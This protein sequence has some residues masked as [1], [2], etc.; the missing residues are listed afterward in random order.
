MRNWVALDRSSYTGTAN[1][2]GLM[3]RMFDQRGDLVKG[4]GVIVLAEVPV[5]RPKASPKVD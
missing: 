1:N 2:D 3:G 4:W 5:G